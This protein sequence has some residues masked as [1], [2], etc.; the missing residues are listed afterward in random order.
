MESGTTRSSPIYRLSC[1]TYFVT[2]PKSLKSDPEA[3]KA[4]LAYRVC[5]RPYFGPP[6]AFKL[7]VNFEKATAGRLTATGRFVL[8]GIEDGTQGKILIRQKDLSNEEVM[9][10]LSVIRTQEIFNLANEPI[11][12]PEDIT[13]HS[14]LDPT[15]WTFERWQV[16]P[17]R[18]NPD[19]A[20][21]TSVFRYQSD[22]GPAEEVF[23]AFAAH[24]KKLIVPDLPTNTDPRSESK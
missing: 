11:Y 18:R 13:S 22:S 8:K 23:S 1:N 20:V 19:I 12:T 15:A 21:F 6:L 16:K 24:A 7:Y 17:D 3:K 9:A 5:I 14:E 2:T 10:L 4:D